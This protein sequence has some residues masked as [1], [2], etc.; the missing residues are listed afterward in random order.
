MRLIK[1]FTFKYTRE[2]IKIYLCSF[3]SD[4]TCSGTEDI[5][6]G[7]HCGSGSSAVLDAI[8]QS[9]QLLNNL[10]FIFKLE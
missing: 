5:K 3:M 6:C 7:L 4:S 2:Y 9:Q 8:T 10:N 1:L